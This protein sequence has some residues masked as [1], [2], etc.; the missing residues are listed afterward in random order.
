MQFI[1]LAY[2]HHWLKTRTG[3]S[4]SKK[5]DH[6]TDRK[7]SRYELSTKLLVKEHQRVA[8]D[9]QTKIAEAPLIALHTNTWISR[10]GSIHSFLL[11]IP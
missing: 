2:L 11:T 1:H 8:A 6:H 9:V 10:D 5:L 4:F 7:I 3:L